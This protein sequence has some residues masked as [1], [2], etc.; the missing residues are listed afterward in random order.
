MNNTWTDVAHHVRWNDLQS[1]RPFSDIANKY[2]TSWMH[3]RQHTAVNTTH[4]IV[5]RMDI[6]DVVNTTL[7]R[8][9]TKKKTTACNENPTQDYNFKISRKLVQ[10]NITSS[11]V[12]WDMRSI[13]H[14]KQQDSIA[15]LTITNTNTTQ[16]V[17]PLLC[18]YYIIHH[19][20]LN[21]N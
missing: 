3:P 20:T 9:F 2:K 14:Y 13:Q 10:E 21:E 5:G 1:P 7:S 15:A 12:S 6:R 4:V 17:Q 11:L 8:R 18:S 19:T 16:Q